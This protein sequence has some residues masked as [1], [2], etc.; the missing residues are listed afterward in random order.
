MERRGFNFSIKEK[1]EFRRK[2]DGRCLYGQGECPQPN[3][4]RVNHITGAFE[5]YLKGADRRD[6]TDIKQNA[7]MEC[8]SHEAIHDAQERLKVQQLKGERVIYERRIGENSRRR[9]RRT[10]PFGQR[11]SFKRRR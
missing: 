7:T 5:A 9:N 11:N 2:A 3:T 8:P 10:K 1:A 6:I 4:G